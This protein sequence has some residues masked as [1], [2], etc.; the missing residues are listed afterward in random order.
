MQWLY[1]LPAKHII[2]IGGNHDAILEELG[3]EEAQKLLSNCHYLL[4]SFI[5]IPELPQFRFIGCP[6]SSGKSRNSGFQSEEMKQNAQ[7]FALTLKATADENNNKSGI[8]GNTGNKNAEK[9]EN[10]VVVL[11]THSPSVENLISILKPDIHCYGH[12]H[13][14]YGVIRRIYVQLNISSKQHLA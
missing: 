3:H 11:A 8:G 7:D 1:T 5:D 12:Y 14:F 2:V 9:A 4:N 13:D 10:A 6:I